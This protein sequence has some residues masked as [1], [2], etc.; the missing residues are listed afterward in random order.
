M[1]RFQAKRP[2]YEHSRGIVRDKVPIFGTWMYLGMGNNVTELS[3][4][5]LFFEISFSKGQNDFFC[6]SSTTNMVQN[7][8]YPI[9]TQ[10]IPYWK[11]NPQILGI[12]SLST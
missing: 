7:D 2:R 1:Y 9:F 6:E 4:Y 12:F 3:F 5:K 11:D 8:T 10:I